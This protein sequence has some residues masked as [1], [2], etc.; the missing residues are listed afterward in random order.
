MSGSPSRTQPA[1][2][3]VTAVVLD[4][5]TVPVIDVT[6]G[7]M[8]E[9]L[10]ARLGDRGIRL[11]IAYDIGQVRDILTVTRR[12]THAKSSSTRPYVTP[13]PLLPQPQEPATQRG[14]HERDAAAP[15]Q[16]RIRERQPRGSSR[17]CHLR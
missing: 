15:G 17:R 4:C 10:G 5:Q 14:V 3:G 16:H 6:A 7:R 9:E 1:V 2:P 12:T 8:L 11:V 13:W